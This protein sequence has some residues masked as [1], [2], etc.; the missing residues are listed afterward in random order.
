M[1]DV[2]FGDG[3]NQLLIA[4]GYH[5]IGG[6]FICLLQI[7]VMS[8]VPFLVLSWTFLSHTSG[9]FSFSFP[10]GWLDKTDQVLPL[11]GRSLI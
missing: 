9:L 1:G 4:F 7:W 10:R 3:K 6:F 2:E 8:G 11:L 5:F